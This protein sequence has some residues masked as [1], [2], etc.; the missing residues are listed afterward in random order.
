MAYRTWKERRKDVER[1][2]EKGRISYWGGKEQRKQLGDKTGEN[3]KEDRG[4]VGVGAYVKHSFT[5]SG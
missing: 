2:M 1:W 4:R 5:S 3:I